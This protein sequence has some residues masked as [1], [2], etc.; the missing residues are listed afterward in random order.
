MQSLRI[1]WRPDAGLDVA[2]LHL[3]IPQA[4]GV[5]DPEPFRARARG[6]GPAL[7]E[8]FATSG[9]MRTLHADGD[10]VP[11][12]FDLPGQLL[13][14]VLAGTLVLTDANGA[15]RVLAA[16]DLLLVEGDWPQPPPVRL[17]GEGRLLQVRV[18]SD[19]PGPRTRPLA[20]RA[21]EARPAGTPRFS[22][23]SRGSDDRSRFSD[24]AALFAPRGQWSA[25]IPL[26]G[27]RFIGMAPDTFIDWHPEIVNNL[28]VVMTGGLELE[29]GGD[30][31]ATQVFW[32]GDVCLAAD[33]T[34]EGHIDRMHGFV[35]VAVLIVA[36]EHLW[37]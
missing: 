13:T 7:A 5:I 21:A 25:I 37:P 18:E 34:G 19:W 3:R 35:Q 8:A 10:A 27:L 9:G 23:M 14:F 28:V 6:E 15:E 31:G 16:G 33:R 11:P 30:G 20:L 26:I 12:L 22:R 17:A 36:D 32:P 4:A 1:S 29:V 24:F 2:P